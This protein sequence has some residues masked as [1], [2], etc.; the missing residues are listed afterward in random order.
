MSEA[1]DPG[2]FVQHHDGT[3]HIDL[4]I[5][6]VGCAGCLLQLP[7]REVVVSYSHSLRAGSLAAATR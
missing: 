4:A 5:E 2:T 7:M 3:A 1:L 6:G